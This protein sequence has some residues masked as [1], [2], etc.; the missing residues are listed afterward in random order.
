MNQDR[1]YLSW[2][3]EQISRESQLVWDDESALRSLFAEL[4]RRKSAGARGLG[5]SVFER[6]KKLSEARSAEESKP[7]RE[8]KYQSSGNSETPNRLEEL[9]LEISRLK[10]ELIT[11]KERL[12]RQESEHYRLFRKVG[13]HIDCPDFVI[14]EARRAY[15]KALHSDHKPEHHK[16]AAEQRFK[17]MEQ[18]FDQI[19]RIRAL[20]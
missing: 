7:R 10:S 20:S 16:A 15:R 2:S 19:F 18:V 11:A 6:I 9:L 17:E 1:P 8:G 3:L 13:I 14:K 4:N 12:A 5:T